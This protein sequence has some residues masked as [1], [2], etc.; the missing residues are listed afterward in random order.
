L[1]ILLL[2]A[3]LKFTL[4]ERYLKEENALNKAN[5]EKIPFVEA[6]MTP[7]MVIEALLEDPDI[8]S[9]EF[10]EGE[11]KVLTKFGPKTFKVSFRKEEGSG[12]A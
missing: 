5:L 11:F 2:S 7:E 8:I 6:K 3:I 12:T 4:Q 1:T 10:E 9:A